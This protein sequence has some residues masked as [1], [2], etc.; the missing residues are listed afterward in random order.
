M[1]CKKTLQNVISDYVVIYSAFR[2]NQICVNFRRHLTY[3]GQ[4][5]AATR[6]RRVPWASINQKY[7]CGRG[8]AAKVCLVYLAPKE[9]V[10]WL[11]MSFSSATFEA[12]SRRE[13][14]GIWERGGKGEW[15]ERVG[16]EGSGENTP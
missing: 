2:N 8:S 7:V 3:I 16:T 4:H 15:K 12:T 11:Q 13:K 10:W 9:R 5:F 14:D 6:N 1:K